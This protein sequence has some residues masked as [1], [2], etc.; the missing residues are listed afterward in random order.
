MTT[1]TINEL[2]EDERQELLAAL[3]GED[4]APTKKEVYIDPSGFNRIKKIKFGAITYDVPSMEYVIRLEQLV[5]NQ[6]QKINRMEQA[7]SKL[8]RMVNGT[9]KFIKSQTKHINE[10]QHDLD[11]KIDI[12]E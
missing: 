3:Y 4:N 9:R 11:Q 10:I 8:E 5:S 2:A 12:R 7:I 1:R 6:S